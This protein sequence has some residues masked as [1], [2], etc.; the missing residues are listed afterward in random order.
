MDHEL[1]LMGFISEGVRVI[2]KRNLEVIMD[3][4]IQ[5]TR[6]CISYFMQDY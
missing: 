1:R 5:D 4:Q 6:I 2:N 3:N